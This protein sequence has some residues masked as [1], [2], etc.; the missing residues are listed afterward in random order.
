MNRPAEM[1]PREQRLDRANY[2]LVVDWSGSMGERSCAGE[3]AS[4]ADAARAVIG[5]WLDRV[6]VDANVGMTIFVGGDIFGAVELG[7][8]NR[9]DI[10]AYLD[11]VYPGGGTPLGYAMADGME[12]LERQAWAQDGYGRYVLVNLTDGKANAGPIEA[13]LQRVRGNRANPI[14]TQTIGFC[15]GDS[16]PLNQEDVVYYTAD[17]PT[18]LAESFDRVLAEDRDFDNTFVDGLD[19]EIEPAPPAD[20]TEAP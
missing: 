10:K 12:A 3:F 4:K 6:P 8:N 15:I 11:R 13:A 19:L 9:A 7:R 20:G 2:Q 5:D 18:A 1:P 16:H 17:D 14:E